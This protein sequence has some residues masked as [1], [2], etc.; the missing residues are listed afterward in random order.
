MAHHRADAPG[1]HPAA[2]D[3][4]ATIL[5][6]RQPTS[7]ARFEGRRGA[8]ARGGNRP[9]AG[10][11]RIGAGIGLAL[12]AITAATGLA[13]WLMP[14]AALIGPEDTVDGTVAL[15]RSWGA[16]G[17][18]GSIG[19]MVVHSFLPFPAEIVACANGMIWGPVWGTAI[20]WIGAMLGAAFAFGLV[21][22]LGRPLLRRLLS[23]GQ[24][25][26]L[27]DWS[28]RQGGAALLVSRLIPLIAFNLIN[29]AAALAGISWWTFLWATGLG[30][31]PLTILLAIL[32]DRMIELPVW[33]WLVLG[34][35]AVASWLFLQRRRHAG[36]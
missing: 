22:R 12:L 3:P 13:W 35:L 24:R 1:G 16:W 8:T 6:G 15:I 11:R 33:A 21:R 32:G 2:G 10:Q 17:M 18:L 29:Y 27:D 7:R 31:L 20:T 19:L 23:A 25:Q 34:T 36:G 26:R 28:T 9:M 4:G 30:I 14:P 5:T